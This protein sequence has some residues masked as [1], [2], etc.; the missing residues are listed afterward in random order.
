MLLGGPSGRVIL[1]AVKKRPPMHVVPSR[2]TEKADFFN[3][4]RDGTCR[5]HVNYQFAIYEALH[6]SD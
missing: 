5:D 4:R 3:C 6:H 1:T 2:N